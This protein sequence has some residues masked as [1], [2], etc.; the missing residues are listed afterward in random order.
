M[1]SYHL[2]DGLSSNAKLFSDDTSLFPVIHDVDTS[3]N[4][5]HKYLYQI[6]KWAFQWKM[7]FNPYPRKQAQEIIF[8]RKIEKIS[9]PSLRFSNII[10]SQST[11]QEHLGIFLDAR[12]TFKEH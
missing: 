1:S 9:Q 5:L 3:A 2:A 12:L 10:V 8:I 6:N 7:S 4:E 11:Y